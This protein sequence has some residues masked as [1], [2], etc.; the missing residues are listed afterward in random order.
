M[1]SKPPRD[2]R[3]NY[4]AD[5]SHDIVIPDIH[6]DGRIF[7]LSR[8]GLYFESDERVEPGDQISITIKK[9][10]G[11]E[12]TFEVE[13]LRRKRLHGAAYRFGYGAPS[14]EPKSSLVKVFD[15]DL[16]PTPIDNKDSREYCRKIYNKLLQFRHESKNHNA[17]IRDI[18]R[19]GAF[20]ETNLWFPVGKRIVLTIPAKKARKAVRLQGWIV[21]C[22]EA[23]FGIKFN[24][25]TDFVERRFD[26]DRRK[27]PDRRHK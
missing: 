9:M 26:V 15:K 20:I 14:I 8:E 25:R 24:R 21:R 2:K 7:N 13:I 22:S 11:N 3:F 6:Y 18:S 23:G 19:G 16:A 17:W 5:L 10:D 12:V 27:G 1:S 4:E